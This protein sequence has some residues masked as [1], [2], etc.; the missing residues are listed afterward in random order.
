VPGKN[1]VQIGLRGFWPPPQIFE[2]MREQ[3]MRW[4]TM[5]DV[6]RRGFDVVLDEAM[7]QALDGP[8]RI[9]ISVDVDVLDP[10]FAPGTGTPEPGGMSARELLRAVRTVALE[11]DLAG[12]DVVELS[13]P[14]DPT[15]ISAEA[16]HRVVLEI[17]S[18]LAARRL[19]RD[20]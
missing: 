19:N 15:G 7:Q 9:Y 5:Y 20:G 17:L 16:A 8:E 1:F 11:T 6:D 18:A 10:A 4:H 3:G 13:P 12:A 14:Y 2:W